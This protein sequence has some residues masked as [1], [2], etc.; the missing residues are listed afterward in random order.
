VAG[1]TGSFGAGGNDAWVLKL[2]GGNSGCN[3]AGSSSAVANNTIATVTVTTITG[4]DTNVSPQMSLISTVDTNGTVT[5]V[6]DLVFS[7]AIL[8]SSYN[9][10]NVRVGSSSTAQTFTLTNTGTAYLFIGTISFSGTNATEFS[11]LNDGCS[12][13]TLAASGSC[14]F[15][16]IFSPVSTDEKSANLS[17]PS[18][19][20]TLNVPLSGTGVVT[21]LKT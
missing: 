7:S 5:N 18:N 9:F 4:T 2:G 21:K 6:C 17:I 14:T 20:P 1:G 19:A 11:K 16:V 13:Q 10:G 15:R 8:P 12:G 3:I